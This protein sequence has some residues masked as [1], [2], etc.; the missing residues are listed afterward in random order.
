MYIQSTR[1]EVSSVQAR[2]RA[3]G[4]PTQVWQ[5]GYIMNIPRFVPCTETH[6]LFLIKILLKADKIRLDDLIRKLPYPAI[7]CTEASG[8][9]LVAGKVREWAPWLHQNK[10]TKATRGKNRMGLVCVDDSPC[11]LSFSIKTKLWNYGAERYQI[12]LGFCHRKK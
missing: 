1:L 10:R 11:V 9:H 2:F 3:E 5:V 6:F 12:E 4:I 7:T 8:H